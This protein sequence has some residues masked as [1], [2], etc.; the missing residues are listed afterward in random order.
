MERAAFLLVALAA[1][2]GVVASRGPASGRADE[3]ATPVFG[4]KTPLDTATGG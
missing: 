1:V 2:A 4:V 3:E